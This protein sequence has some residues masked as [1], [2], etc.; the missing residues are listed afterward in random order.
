M[1]CKISFVQ[2]TSRI[3][4]FAGNVNI[5]QEWLDIDTHV[6]GV[7]PLFVVNVQVKEFV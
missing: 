1:M 7:P 3:D 6:E 5:P 4:D 2:C